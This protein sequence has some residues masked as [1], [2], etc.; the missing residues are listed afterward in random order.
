MF[1]LPSDALPTPF[2]DCVVG[3]LLAALELRHPGT[4]RHAERTAELALQLTAMV[5]PKLARAEGLGHAYLLHDI[6]K[7]GI[8]EA[9]ILK[10]ER[11]TASEMRVMRTHA[12]LGEELVRRLRCLSPHV[13]EVVGGHHERW[14]GGGYPRR[15]AGLEIPLAARIFA[16]V[17]AYDAMTQMRSY[18]KPVS[19]V[20][21]LQ[22]LDRC[23]GTQ[24]DP[25]VVE[26]FLSCPRDAHFLPK[27]LSPS[28]VPPSLRTA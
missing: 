3:A 2:A 26:A 8:P 9:I 23:A 21:A 11:L 22:E 18:R 4:C 1:D 24:F 6:G 17:D 25:S 12:T 19:T 5:D 20:E 7:L 14:D 27:R 16:V 13:S 15:R 28:Q 10:P